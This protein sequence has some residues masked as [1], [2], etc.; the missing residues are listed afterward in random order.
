MFSPTETKLLVT[1]LAWIIAYC[2]LISRNIFQLNSPFFSTLCFGF[3]LIWQNC[4]R[5]QENFCAIESHK[6][7]SFIFCSKTLLSDYAIFAELL[8]WSRIPL[9]SSWKLCEF[10]FFFCWKP[11]FILTVWWKNVIWLQSKV[12]KKAINDFPS[13]LKSFTIKHGKTTLF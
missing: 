11:P 1:P 8:L 9:E 5:T 4:W 13:W 10:I 2:K 6:T 3:I 7:V 12:V